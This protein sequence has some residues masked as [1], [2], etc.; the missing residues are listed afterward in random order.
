MKIPVVIS[1][2][3]DD[4]YFKAVVIIAAQKNPVFIIGDEANEYIFGAIDNVQHVHKSTLYTERLRAFEASFVNYSSNSHEEELRCFRRVFLVYQLMI[5]KG[6]TQ[7]FHLDS[8]CVLLEDISSIFPVAPAI[9]LIAYAMMPNY[10]PFFM[11]GCIHNALLSVAFCEA[12]STLCEDIYINRSKFSLI[13]PKIEWHQQNKVGGGICDMTMYYL[14]QSENIVSV[15][16]LNQ[17]FNI[18]SEI[19]IFDHNINIE[20]GP[21]GD[22]TFVLKNGLKKVIRKNEKYYCE[23][24]GGE[25]VRAITLHFQGGAKKFISAIYAVG[26]T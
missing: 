14:L 23:T 1:H 22:Q 4:A 15:L 19:C 10:H 9:P 3:G 24:K 17:A 11:A 12:F 8:D 21:A 18:H 7:V 25:L 2:S 6:Y 16:D 20:F 13:A 26:N 5:V